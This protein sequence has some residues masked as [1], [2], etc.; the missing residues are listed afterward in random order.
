[1]EI[2]ETAATD[3]PYL[4]GRREWNERYGSYI[5]RESAWRWATMVALL[6][7]LAAV[8]GLVAVARQTKLVPYVVEVDRLGAAV[9]VKRADQTQPADSRVVRSQL[10]RWLVAVRSVVGDAEGQRYL[11]KEAYATINKN[12]ASYAA[13][14]AMYSDKSPLKRAETETV[15]VEVRSVLAISAHTWRIEWDE[16]VRTHD[17]RAAVAEPWQATVTVAVN[18]PSDE[19]T[20]LLNPMGIYITTF[21]WS[22]RL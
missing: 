12:G 17:G 7:A 1:M 20:I 11:L 3:N 16:T 18:P 14:N 6:V 9:G 10:A 15:A 19:G 21:N 8:M 2:A 13:L 5:A 4:N 22:K